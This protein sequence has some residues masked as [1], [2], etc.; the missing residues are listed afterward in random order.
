M[1]IA[2]TIHDT[3]EWSI[4]TLLS[5]TLSSEDSLT[6][7]EAEDHN[8]DIDDGVVY[9]TGSLALDITWMFFCTIITG[10]TWI[11]HMTHDYLEKNDGAKSRIYPHF[12]QALK[13]FATGTS[14]QASETCFRRLILMMHWKEQLSSGKP[15]D[16]QQFYRAWEE[17]AP[18]TK[19][20]ERLWPSKEEAR[21]HWHLTNDV[22]FSFVVIASLKRT[23]HNQTAP[24]IL[25]EELP[26]RFHERFTS[27]ELFTT[28]LALAS[29]SKVVLLFENAFHT[30]IPL[31]T[32]VEESLEID[33]NLAYQV[34]CTYH[35][36]DAWLPVFHER[37]DTLPF[38]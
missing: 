23:Y 30:Y 24:Y 26:T 3:I 32:R 27:S 7:R 12:L 22:H 19:Y 13:P 16:V 31:R 35:E 17:H 36:G 20:L 8:I 11:N 28:S 6:R 9:H 2:H 4:L 18:H 1:H 37:P 14:E 25:Y 21:K 33:Y 38:K 10:V 29:S 34:C 15:E 5:H